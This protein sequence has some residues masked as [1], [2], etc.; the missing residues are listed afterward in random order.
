M[1]LECDRQ[2]QIQIHIKIQM[3]P[4]SQHSHCFF[5]PVVSATVPTPPPQTPHEKRTLHR[6]RFYI[7]FADPLIRSCPFVTLTSGLANSGEGDES[8][9]RLQAS[10]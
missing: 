7:S 2:Q 5:L 9:R 4:P 6:S 8:S 3:G 1:F 10:A